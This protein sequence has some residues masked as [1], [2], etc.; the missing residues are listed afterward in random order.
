MKTTPMTLTVQLP[1]ECKDIREW[2]AQQPFVLIAAKS[3]CSN[4]G[5]AILVLRTKDEITL[6]AE[7]TGCLL[8]QADGV[9]GIFMAKVMQDAAP[10]LPPPPPGPKLH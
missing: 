6:T 1:D 2:L 4:H 7:E 8:E 9:F 5:L 3:G 10:Q